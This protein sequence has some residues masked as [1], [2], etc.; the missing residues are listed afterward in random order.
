MEKNPFDA[1]P[2]SYP[3][4]S[5]LPQPGENW[6]EGKRVKACQSKW[7]CGVGMKRMRYMGP[8]GWHPAAHQR[9][10]PQRHKYQIMTNSDELEK[11]KQ[12]CVF[13]FNFSSRDLPWVVHRI[14]QTPSGA[15]HIS[16][17]LDHLGWMS[18]LEGM[19]Q[20][21]LELGNCVISLKP[22]NVQISLKTFHGV[23]RKVHTPPHQL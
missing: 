12:N 19:E 4:V 13:W 22:T 23:V 14:G 18:S 16:I 10:V 6:V 11:T 17:W 20:A 3:E 7:M 5:Q 21:Y 2:Y 9:N 1:L 15:A 8:S